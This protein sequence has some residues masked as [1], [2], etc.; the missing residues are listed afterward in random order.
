MQKLLVIQDDALSAVLQDRIVKS[1]EFEGMYRRYDA[2]EEAHFKTFRWIVAEDTQDKDSEEED[3]Q[4]D[5]DEISQDEDD[6]DSQD[7]NDEDSQ[8]DDDEDSQDDDGYEAQD[9]GLKNLARAKFTNWLSSGSGIFHISGKLGSGKSTLM[10]FICENHHTKNKLEL[11]AG[12][13]RLS[14]SATHFGLADSL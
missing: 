3:S 6:E 10:K 8:D 12:R 2:V 14:L 4:D 9:N 5:D 1:L 13:Y 11:W 7:G